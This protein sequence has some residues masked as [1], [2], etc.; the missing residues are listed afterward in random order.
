M[1]GFTEND[2]NRLFTHHPQSD[3]DVKRYE[4]IRAAGRDFAKVLL[5]NTPGCAEQTIAVRRAHEAV[6]IANAAVACH[7]DPPTPA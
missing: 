3:A 5:D 2:I 1:P 4:R 6:M 7:G